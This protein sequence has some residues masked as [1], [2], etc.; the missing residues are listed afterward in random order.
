MPHQ[1][2]QAECMWIFNVIF[3]YSLHLNENNIKIVTQAV[4]DTS[5]PMRMELV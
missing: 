5:P 2:R 1:V 4:L 3:K